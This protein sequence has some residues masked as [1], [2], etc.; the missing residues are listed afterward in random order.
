MI[1]ILT[2][3]MNSRKFATIHHD[4]KADNVQP[5]PAFAGMTK[6]CVRGAKGDTS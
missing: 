3:V 4:M 5:I 1:V 2:R 6:R